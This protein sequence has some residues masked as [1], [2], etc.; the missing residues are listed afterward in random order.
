MNPGATTRPVTSTSTRPWSGVAE[1][2]GDAS[3]GDADVAHRVEAGLGI[4]D[5]A[6]VQHDVV[7]GLGAE[8]SGDERREREQSCQCQGQPGC[9]RSP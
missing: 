6:S 2:G 7:C 8:V 5:P 4:E 3:A 1:S 9:R